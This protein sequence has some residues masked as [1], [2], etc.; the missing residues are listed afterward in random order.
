MVQDYICDDLRPLDNMLVTNLQRHLNLISASL[1]QFIFINFENLAAN[2]QGYL[3]QYVIVVMYTSI[4]SPLA[5]R[6]YVSA[7]NTACAVVKRMAAAYPYALS[8]QYGE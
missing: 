1:P 4:D 7:F 8:W 6:A 2:I 5:Y 3:N